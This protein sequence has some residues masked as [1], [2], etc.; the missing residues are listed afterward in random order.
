MKEE[1]IDWV[2][3]HLV[4]TGAATTRTGLAGATG[5]TGEEIAASIERLVGTMLIEVRG[6]TICALSL[7]EMLIRN[8]CRYD[9][10]LP[11]VIENGVIRPKKRS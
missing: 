5:L 2:V 8:Q 10:S 7:Q 9:Q 6:E 11:F 3:F 4:D 1:D